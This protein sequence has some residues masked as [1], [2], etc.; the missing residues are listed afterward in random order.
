MNSIV[1]S[2]NINRW[3]ALPLTLFFC[4]TSAGAAGPEACQ[5]IQ[6]SSTQHENLLSEADQENTGS[7]GICQR[8]RSQFGK[9]RRS[10]KKDCKT[11]PTIYV[12]RILVASS[13][14]SSQ[15]ISKKQARQN[16]SFLQGL[17]RKYCIDEVWMQIMN[18]GKTTTHMRGT[19]G[20]Q[21]IE[22]I[23]VPF[24]IESCRLF[25]REL[26]PLQSRYILQS[27]CG[28]DC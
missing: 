8:Y 20:S 16:N 25:R 21:G 24:G 5:R 2:E 14:S 19:S 7:A 4:R 13:K 23:Q 10:D 6:A 28:H 1:F 12:W 22:Q 27:R 15:D 17:R 3:I 18:E 11:K 26:S 9:H